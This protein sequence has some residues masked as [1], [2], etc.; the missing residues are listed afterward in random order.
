MCAVRSEIIKK[1]TET[2]VSVSIED[3]LDK[4]EF[5]KAIKQSCI[6]F[7]IHDAEANVFSTE[8]CEG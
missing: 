3:L 4:K 2:F 1:D 5:F 8:V 6:I 7:R